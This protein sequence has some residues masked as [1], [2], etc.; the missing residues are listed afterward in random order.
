LLSIHV[1]GRLNNNQSAAMG[2]KTSA[3]DLVKVAQP[4]NTP[5]LASH[6]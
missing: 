1:R 6:K 2:M 4:S 3:V 5:P